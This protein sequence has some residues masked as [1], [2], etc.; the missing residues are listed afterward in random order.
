VV[1]GVPFWWRESKGDSAPGFT[2]VYEAF[3]VIHPWSVGRYSTADSYH[4]LR[5]SVQ[6]PDKRCVV[7]SSVL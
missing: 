4:N 2:A 5:T 6:V 3:D 7:A 1:G